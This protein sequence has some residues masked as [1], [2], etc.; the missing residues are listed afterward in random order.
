MSFFE[1]QYDAWMA[2]DC[3]GRLEDYDGSEIDVLEADDR[4]ITEQWY[5]G[6]SGRVPFAPSERNY[7]TKLFAAP[8]KS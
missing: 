2:N 8:E 1:D 6:I 3:Q 7:Y 4:E 5:K